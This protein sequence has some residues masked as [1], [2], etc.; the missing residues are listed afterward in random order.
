[1]GTWWLG[2]DS[3]DVRREP[4]AVLLLSYVYVAFWKAKDVFSFVSSYLL[5][6]YSITVFK[7]YPLLYFYVTSMGSL[8]GQRGILHEQVCSLAPCSEI[9]RPFIVLF[10]FVTLR[11]GYG[12]LCDAFLKLILWRS[13]N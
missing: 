7:N 10:I 4:S 13:A 3:V 5:K 9:S 1:M 11:K 6:V 12:Y 8:Q 2:F